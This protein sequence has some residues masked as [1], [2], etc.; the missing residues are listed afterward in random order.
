LLTDGEE[1]GRSTAAHFAPEKK[2]NW[3]FEFDRAG[4]DCVL[5]EFQDSDMVGLVEERG[6]EV[7]YG[8][9]SDICSLQHLGV[10]GFNFGTGY[11]EPHT[12]N[13]HANINET[14]ASAIMFVD[15]AKDLHGTRLPHKE[16]DMIVEKRESW[17]DYSCED[18]RVCYY[19]GQYCDED[20]IFCP[21][22][23]TR[24]DEPS[25]IPL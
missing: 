11:H 25:T 8:S 20:W 4:M 18:D 19:C 16:R 14:I 1:A 6:F 13:C 7:G 5:Y 24:I 12:P 2:Y 9:F 23:A 3:I 15:F 22:C 21:G 17:F 10:K